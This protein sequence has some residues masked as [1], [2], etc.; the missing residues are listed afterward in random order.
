MK[1]TFA[2]FTETFWES[3]DLTDA[4]EYGDIRYHFEDTFIDVKLQDLADLLTEEE[5][6]EMFDRWDGSD[7][8]DKIDEILGQDKSAREKVEELDDED[9]LRRVFDDIALDDAEQSDGFEKVLRELY[10][11]WLD[12]NRPGVKELRAATGMTQ[13]EFA[14][15]FGIPQR[16]IEDW[17]TKRRNVSEYLVDLMEYKLHKEGLDMTAERIIA[18]S[19]LSDKDKKFVQRLIDK[20]ILQVHKEDLPLLKH[21]INN[22]QLDGYRPMFYGGYT[23]E[24]FQKEQ[25]EQF[26]CEVD[27]EDRQWYTVLPEGIIRYS[28]EPG[29]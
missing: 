12:E 2:Q 3:Y 13:K 19:S 15:Y 24:R 17:E 28:D 7:D 20:G 21:W 8:A 16:T 27:L 26:G 22:E 4:L 5:L 23:P 10:G 6:Q 25:I 11:A 1:K 9:L 18:E 14:E 29:W